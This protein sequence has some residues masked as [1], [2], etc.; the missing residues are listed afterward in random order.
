M[1]M[2]KGTVEFL[3]NQA[4]AAAGKAVVDHGVDT[5]L[6]D[7]NGVHRFTKDDSPQT[8]HVHTLTGLVEAIQ[9]GALEQTVASIHVHDADRVLVYGRLDKYG[10]R[11][12]LLEASPFTETMNFGRF[13]DQED[14][15]I[16]LRS[17][18]VA[19]EHREILIEFA[20]NLVEKNEQGYTDD[21]IS[22][23]AT[24]K[25]GVASVAKAI[26]PSPVTLQPYRTF[27]EVEQPASEFIFRVQKGPEMALFE[28][29]G[30]AWKNTA[31]KSVAA[32][33]MA[34]LPDVHIFA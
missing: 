13:Y 29:D 2:E 33:L 31:I 14:F 8:L 19:N 17:R 22:Q 24:V 11:P 5:F 1:D 30:N 28:S 16:S 20:G 7:N 26:V 18:F 27:I 9:K 4:V 34:E 21:G 10:H 15:Q 32:Y 12:I 3:A 23:Q 25:N 6:I